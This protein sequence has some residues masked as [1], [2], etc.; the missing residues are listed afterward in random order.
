MLIYVHVIEYSS[1]G[2][3]EYYLLK[4]GFDQIEKWHLIIM[5]F[6]FYRSSNMN[7][8]EY[9]IVYMKYSSYFIWKQFS[10]FFLYECYF[11]G[12]MLFSFKVVP[13]PFLSVSS[14]FYWISSYVISH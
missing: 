14:I 1:E 4:N 7:T 2:N 13:L 9:F 3:T 11:H 12:K 5:L 8:F 10:V 6:A